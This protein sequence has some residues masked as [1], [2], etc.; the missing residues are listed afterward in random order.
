MSMYKI[1]IIVYCYFLRKSYMYPNIKN[2]SRDMY[3]LW[4]NVQKDGKDKQEERECVCVSA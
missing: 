2:A 1:K 4:S 3:V